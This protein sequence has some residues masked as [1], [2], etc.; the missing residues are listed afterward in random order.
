MFGRKQPSPFNRPGVK[1]NSVSF[2]EVLIL[3]MIE[4]FWGFIFEVGGGDMV[5]RTAM[6][7]LI[8]VSIYAGVWAIDSNKSVGT[9]HVTQGIM[10]GIGIAVMVV[11]IVLGID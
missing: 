1:I 7:L 10:F 6:G 4:P 2:F 11:S 9:Q 8:G 3:I 5:L